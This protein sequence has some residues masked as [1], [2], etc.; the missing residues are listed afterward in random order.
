MAP[1]T[2]AWTAEIAIVIASSAAGL[3]KFIFLGQILVRLDSSSM[4]EPYHMKPHFEIKKNMSAS[5]HRCLS[6]MQ[7]TGLECQTKLDQIDQIDLTKLLSDSLL[8]TVYS[9]YSRLQTRLQTLDSRLY[10]LIL[11]CIFSFLMIMGWSP[12]GRYDAIQMQGAI[13]NLLIQ[14]S[15]FKIPES[16]W[17]LLKGK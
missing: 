5:R 13:L 2:G 6:D 14:H 8:Y 17:T 9:V 7:L 15:P 10:T 4:Q 1:A 12:W 11:V 16:Y 3:F